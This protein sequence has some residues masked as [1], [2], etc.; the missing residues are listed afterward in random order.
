VAD[1]HR[2]LDVQDRDITLDQL[3]HRRET[4]PERASLTERTQA[5]ARIDA[6]LTDLQAKLADLQRG[7]KRIEDEVEVIDTKSAAETKK[8]NSGS[9][10]APREIQ[11]LSD[12]IDA[13]GRRK[14]VLEDEEIELMEQAEPL[15]ATVERLE[16]ERAD[17]AAEADRLRAA[18][19]EQEQAIDAEATTISAERAA[20]AGDLPEA[21]LAQYEKLRAK[22]GGVGAARLD[23]DR[24]LGCHI[25]LPAMEVDAI[26]HAPPDAVVTHEECGRIL[27]R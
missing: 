18:V 14:R 4:L 2:L 13:L 22:L 12:E 6:E 24:C 15:A 19:A 1:L 8:L 26:K 16:Q 23:G 21:L 11:A 17:A 10:T 27:V 7:Q 25:S 3:R 9:I 20:A 5:I